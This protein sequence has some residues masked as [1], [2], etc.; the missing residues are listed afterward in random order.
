VLEASGTGH[1]YC[2]ITD[3]DEDKATFAW[4]CRDLRDRLCDGVGEWIGGTGKYRA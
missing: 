2:V 4:Q 1:G 3:E